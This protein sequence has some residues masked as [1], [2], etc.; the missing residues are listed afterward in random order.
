M[1]VT[2]SGWLRAANATREGAVQLRVVSRLRRQ[3]RRWRAGVPT[4]GT[5]VVAM[6]F[7]APRSQRTQDFVHREVPSRVRSASVSSSV[8]RPPL[9]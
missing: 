4:S 5:S 1:T 7:G 6:E 9:S 2:R 8:V 3:R